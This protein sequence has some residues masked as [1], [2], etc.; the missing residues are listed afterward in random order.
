MTML[1]KF[2]AAGLTVVAMAGTAG[3]VTL[4]GMF[5]VTVARITGASSSGSEANLANFYSAVSGGVTDDF[6]YTGDLSFRVGSGNSGSTTISSWLATGTAGGVAGLDAGIGG[7]QQ[8]NGNI[9]TSTAITTFYLFSMFVPWGYD[10]SINHD[11]GILVL[12][13]G[14]AIGGNAGPTSEITTLVSGF[15]GGF[16]QFLYV[17]TNG[18]PS[19]FEVNGTALAPV[20][21]PAGL[22]LILSAF[23]GLFLLRRRRAAAAA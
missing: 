12:D 8:S 21:V 1:K 13:G 14:T 9:D 11:D 6:I 23:G 3:A 19:V 10:F 2:L 15:D 22:P 16:L 17:A 4:N 18:N 7:L 5:D 20:P